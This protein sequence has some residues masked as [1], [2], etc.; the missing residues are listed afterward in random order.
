[1]KAGVNTGKL[2]AIGRQAYCVI[3]QNAVV[4]T[5]LTKSDAEAHAATVKVNRDV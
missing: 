1:M 2:V 4:V 3:E 5:G